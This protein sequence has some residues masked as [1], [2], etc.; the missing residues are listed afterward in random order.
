LFSVT[1]FQ[2]LYASAPQTYASAQGAAQ[3]PKQ[4]T[5]ILANY[6]DIAFAM[7]D[8]AHL[9]A[10]ELQ[11]KIDELVKRPSPQALQQAKEA[12]LAA[13]VPYQQTE[14]YRFGNPVVDDWEGRVNAWPLD[15]GLIDYV[16]T[17]SYGTTSDDNAFYTANI[18][19]TPALMVGGQQLDARQITPELL[20]QL[21]EIGEFEA[22]VATGYHAI[23]FLLWG[24]DL[25]G[26]L[27]GAGHR[28]FTDY[29]TQRCTVGNCDRRGAYL[30]SAAQL[31]VD[32][33]AEMRNAWAANGTARNQLWEKS[34][35][36]GLAMILTGLGSLS[37]GEL[38]GERMKLGL[39]LHDPEE[40]HDCFADNTHNSH[41]YNIVG[42]ISIYYGEYVRTDG[43]VISGPSLQAL[44]AAEHPGVNMEITNRLH[45]TLKAAT[46][47]KKL[48]ESGKRYDQMLARNDTAGNQVLQNVVDRLVDQ[49]RALEMATV[50]LRLPSITF[51]GSDSLDNPMAV[52]E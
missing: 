26:T 1:F 16:D 6:A 18:I 25:N 13:R 5:A 33:L 22:N 10:L 37:Y 46:V 12:W 9:A 42:I 36:N 30:Q 11:V 29:D 43:T 39:M 20:L 7:Y 23:E 27:A 35:L 40:E 52:F 14:G 31:L 19:A 45:D 4:T 8:D 44:L 48:A 28:D 51:E 32:D 24:Q 15:E 41:Y 49:S 38:A 3:T 50:A 17:H 47:M 2:T 21:H 34:E